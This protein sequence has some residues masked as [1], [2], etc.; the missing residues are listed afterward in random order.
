ME[1]FGDFFQ[2]ISTPFLIFIGL[3]YAGGA[4]AGYLKPGAGDKLEWDGNNALRRVENILVW[5]G[6]KVFR[7]IS[8]A[9]RWALETLEE[10]SAD[11]GEWFAGS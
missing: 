6:I 2:H 10:A 3:L 11:V 4:V 8:R 9:L 1:T 7:G 5:M